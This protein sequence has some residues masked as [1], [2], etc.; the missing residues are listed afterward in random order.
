MG[1]PTEDEFLQADELSDRILI[2]CAGE[3]LNVV[4]LGLQNVI[5][6]LVEQSA[7]AMR[8][9][10]ALNDALMDAYLAR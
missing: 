6:H 2:A 9:N 10:D 5:L 7:G 1:Y 4:L 8:A 3:E